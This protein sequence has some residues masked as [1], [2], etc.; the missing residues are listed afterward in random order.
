MKTSNPGLH[1][2]GGSEHQDADH[3]RD[4]HSRH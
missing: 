4:P 2:G 1:G 3:R